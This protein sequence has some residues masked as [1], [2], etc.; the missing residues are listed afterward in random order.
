MSLISGIFQSLHRVFPTE[1]ADVWCSRRNDAPP[2]LG[3]TP[4]AYAL[5]SGLPGLFTIRQELD[6]AAHGSFPTTP[7]DRRRESTLPQPDFDLGSD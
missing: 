3:H 7:E 4:L 5:R 6:M 2:F 1:T